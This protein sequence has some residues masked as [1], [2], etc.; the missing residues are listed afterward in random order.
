MLEE[1]SSFV[2]TRWG[3]GALAFEAAAATGEAAGDLFLRDPEFAVARGSFSGL[4]STRQRARRCDANH[5]K[6]EGRE[7]AAC[8][9]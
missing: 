2:N 7:G 1:K 9:A 4:R 6:E 5:E 8:V 3:L